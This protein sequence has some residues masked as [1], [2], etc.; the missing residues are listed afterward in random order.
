MN[1]SCKARLSGR[2]H[3]LLAPSH[4][5]AAQFD[6]AVIDVSL[7]QRL[8]AEAQR[9][10]GRIYLRDGAIKPVDLLADDRHVQSADDRA[11][12]LLT[13][14]ENETVLA[15][16]RYSLHNPEVRFAE[17][18]LAE[19]GIARSAELGRQVEEAVEAEL[20]TARRRAVGFVEL[21]GW[22]VC[23]SLRCTTEAIG[24][25]L[26][27]Y[28]FSQLQGGALGLSSATF[29]HSSSSILRRIGGRPLKANGDEISSYYD[30]QYGCDMELLSFDSNSPNPRYAG[31]ISQYRELIH[32]I[33]VVAC[34]PADRRLSDLLALHATVGWGSACRLEKGE[35]AQMETLGHR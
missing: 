30:S 27:V 15:C 16:I 11:W 2:R 22:A 17:L 28:A 7:H 26:T 18:S 8:L 20:A 24:T 9:L 5:A 31:W 25:L 32:E 34:A 4:T 12:H 13:V 1:L 3:V 10:R 35:L 6:R 23:E 14:D 29:R 21:G 19:S 33:P